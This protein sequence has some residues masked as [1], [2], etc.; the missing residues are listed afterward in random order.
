MKNK[1]TLIIPCAGK[2]TRFPNLPPKWTLLNDHDTSMLDM[3]MMPYRMQPYAQQVDE[4]IV[5]VTK[6]QFV[7]NKLFEFL[8]NHVKQPLSLCVLE[9]ETFCAAETV[10]QTIQDYK[11]KGDIIIKDSDCFADYRVEPNCSNYI[12][13]LN[14]ES[15]N[16]V[17]RLASKS[18]IHKDSNNIITD[19]I[20]KKIVSS[21][22][23]VGTYACNSTDFC[24]NY[25]QL[26][27]SPVFHKDE[28]Y[29]S[30]VFS[31][32]ILTNSSVF[33]YVE[34]SNFI[35]FGTLEDW[36]QNKN[37]LAVFDGATNNIRISRNDELL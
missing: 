24:D 19:I 16:E 36:E 18:F 23:C 5:T 4:I 15:N 1:K 32:M 11:I 30:Y 13:G 35:D 17:R 37:K 25:L 2:S 33:L 10:Y 14:I 12:V 28:I 26:K 20:E 9:N 29:V 7:K 27:N 6:Q 3:A 34:S 21:N 22:I 31:N 8:I